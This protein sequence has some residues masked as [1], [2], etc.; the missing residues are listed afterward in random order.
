MERL[1]RRASLFTGLCL[2]IVCLGI[3][4]PSHAIPI[5]GSYVFTNGLTGTF[6]SNGSQLTAWNITLSSLTSTVFCQGCGLQV[7]T[8]SP[9]LFATMNKSVTP[10]EELSLGWG[11]NSWSLQLET[12]ESGTFAYKA[13]TA[14]VP[15]PSVVLLLASGLLA[16]S[17]YGWRQQRQ[18]KLQLN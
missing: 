16:L 8:N 9:S 18:P 13:T 2:M 4:S 5:A 1:R 12:L 3:S 7:Q 15:E 17:L 10:N 6:T 14:G 11:N